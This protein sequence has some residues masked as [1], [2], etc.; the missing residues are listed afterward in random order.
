MKIGL[1][2]KSYI[3]HKLST[4]VAYMRCDERL[5][6]YC[7]KAFPEGECI[8]DLTK[9]KKKKEDGERL[10]FSVEV[11]IVGIWKRFSWI[12]RNNFHVAFGRRK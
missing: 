9:K 7:F 2:L 4:E 6:K 8:A 10:S 3:S 1:P 12:F 5:P 11:L